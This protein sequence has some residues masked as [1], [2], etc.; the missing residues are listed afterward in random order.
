MEA[1]IRAY[2]QWAFAGIPASQNSEDLKEE[3]ILNLIEKYHGELAQ[4]KSENEAY[5]A[6]IAGIGD[7]SELLDSIQP[8]ESV[9]AQAEEEKRRQKRALFLSIAIGLYIL[10]PIAVIVGETM[11]RSEGGVLLM[12]L[13]IAVATGLLIY[14]HTM[15]GNRK[16]QEPAYELYP[17]VSTSPAPSV[18]SSVQEESYHPDHFQ[19]QESTGI[20]GPLRTG[21]WL[22]IVGLYLIASFLLKIWAWSWTI[23]LFGAMI[24]QLVEGVC[25]LKSRGQKPLSSCLGPFHAAWWTFTLGIYFVMNF[26]LQI[27]A[28][29]W[30]FFL[31]AAAVDQILTGFLKLRE[32]SK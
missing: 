21:Y 5:G 25:R 2:I 24:D 6:T 9:Y 12:F 10:S 18:V 7:L 32:E 28:W 31:I 19:Q 16:V 22:L 29:S 8:P 4:G 17:P 1:K 11:W 14:S 13:F 20:P 26:L 15:Y 3:M 23:F 27:W 30:S